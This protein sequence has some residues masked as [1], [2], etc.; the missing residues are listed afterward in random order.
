MWGS[1]ME[2][3]RVAVL[4]AL[5]LSSACSAY[6]DLRLLDVQEIEPPQIEPGGTLRIHGEG[7]PLGRSAVVSLRGTLHRPGVP[8]SPL[9]VR[10]R[11]EV[12]TET[13][14]EVPIDAELMRS[15]GGRATLEGSL[16]LIFRAAND[17]R[18]VFAEQ[19]VLVDFL[20]DTSVQLRTEPNG[21]EPVQSIDGHH[22]GVALSREESGTVGVRIESVDPHS[23]A[24]TQ[25]VRP[26]DTLV[27]L[28]GMRLYS[29]RDFF[30]DP[31]RTES[32][33]WVARPGLAGVHMLRWPHEATERRADPLT[34]GVLLLFG[35]LLG[36]LSP[37]ALQ[38]GKAPSASTE[39]WLTRLSLVLVFVA[40]LFCESALEWTTI[41]ILVLGLLAS[42]FS[43]AARDRVAITS[44]AFAVLSTLTIMLLARTASIAS[45]VAVQGGTALDW[46]LF[47]T[48]A[49]TLAFGSYLYAL[50]Q[51]GGQSRISASLY[52]SAAAVLGAALFLGG[53][54]TAEPVL[55]ISLLVAKAGAI[56][57]GAR[58]FR[59]SREVA[60]SVLGLGLSLALLGAWAGTDVLL[61]Y[62]SPVAVG[63]IGALIVRSIIPAFHRPSV[64]AV[65]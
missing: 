33:V 23:F 42:L 25:G 50:G 15:I 47:R 19:P 53:W 7:F 18:D 28:D 65:A 54:E 40:A 21:D 49:S 60:I 31:S 9:D 35:L 63:C 45:I 55:G 51:L 30:P 64:P 41:W 8:A 48:P 3:M 58:F 24:A 17:R 6:D 26:G 56:L 36:W 10:L 27:G 57:L 46:Y 22:F 1:E 43:L 37:M 20:P 16:R 11:A 38:L 13:L 39:V 4:F 61:P 59:M 52:A 44:F 12:E 5:L 32:S 34:F 2:A 62:W 14:I 29:W